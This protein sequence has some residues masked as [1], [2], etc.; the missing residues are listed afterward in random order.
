[1]T[2]LVKLQSLFQDHVL[3]RNPDAVIAFVGNDIASTESRLG[4]YYDAYRLRLAECLRNDFPGLNAVMGAEPFDA[5]CRRYI[6][7]HPSTYPNVRW[8][9]QH[10]TD[11]LEADNATSR[12][13]Y[14]AEMARFEWA[15][16]LAFD[17]PDAAVMKPDTLAQLTPE[18]WPSLRLQLHPTLHRSEFDWNIGPIWRAVSDDESVPMPVQLETP[19][20]LALW[21]RETTVYWRSLGTP[22]A[23]ALDAFR[24]GKEFAEVCARLCEW[25]T[26][27]EVPGQIA[28]MLR[29][30][31]AEGLLT[32]S[33]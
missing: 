11:F 23:H 16:G 32:E 15:R 31:V 17:G 5:L 24:D 14:L 25:Y 3:T 9:G 1:M 29:Q 13:P 33:E 28:G 18:D 2:G 19:E 20:Q 22:E 7:A 8:V 30:W 26:E 10:L 27:D 21:R 4:V 12:H 6:E